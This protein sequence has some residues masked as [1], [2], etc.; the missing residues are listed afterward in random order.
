LIEGRLRRLGNAKI[1]PHAV[2]IWSTAVAFDDEG[3]AAAK[4]ALVGRRGHLLLS[5]TW[6]ARRRCHRDISHV[7]TKLRGELIQEG[8][9][10]QSGKRHGIVGK[11]DAGAH[12]CA[13]WQQWRCH[14]RRV[15][16]HAT[17]CAVRAV[18]AGGKFCTGS[19]VVASTRVAE[20]ARVQ[21]NAR[22]PW[23]R[24]WQSWRL[25]DGTADMA[26]FSTILTT[27]RRRDLHRR[28][29][30]LCT[31]FAWRAASKSLLAS[32]H[33]H[34]GAKGGDAV[35]AELVHCRQATS[36][37]EGMLGGA[38]QLRSAQLL[39]RDSRGG[40]AREWCVHLCA[41]WKPSWAAVSAVGAKLASRLGSARCLA[42]DAVGA[43]TRAII[44][45]HTVE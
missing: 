20:L 5:P 2:Q 11:G 45:A 39:K 41:R 35:D 40:E 32:R 14:G 7:Q 31:Q 10:R 26:R 3:N 18:G 43:T 15:F 33:P 8:S 24:G 27:A 6:C 38:G 23:R 1:R 13:G 36:H 44:I 22:H 28:W 9:G 30:L 37:E 29:R 16:S 4:H 17:I 25:G 34:V 19:S 12:V 42:A 21:A